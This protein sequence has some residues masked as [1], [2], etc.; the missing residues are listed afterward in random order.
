MRNGTPQREAFISIHPAK[1]GAMSKKQTGKEEEK[2]ECL[3]G[4]SKNL[5]LYMK[6][7]YPVLLIP[8]SEEVRAEQEIA[9]A[10]VATKR[11]RKVVSWTCTSGLSRLTR[12]PGGGLGISVLDDAAKPP[13]KA[14]NKILD[15]NQTGVVYVME[16]LHAHFNNPAVVRLVRDVSRRFR[17]GDRT[18]ILLSPVKKLPPELERDVAVV[19]LALPDRTALRTAWDAIAETNKI[20]QDKDEVEKIMEAARGLTSLEAENAFA[21]AIIQNMTGDERPISELVMAEKADAV[22]KTGVLEYFDAKTI[23]SDIGGLRRL[24]KWLELRKLALTSEAREYGLPSPRGYVMVGLPGCG[25]SLAAKATASVL[26]V[27][28]IRFDVSR[29]FAGLVGQSE[30]NMR[31]AISTI[32]AI[33]NCVVWIDEM[34]KAFAGASGT[35]SGDSGV[36]QRV[37]GQFLTWMQEKKG[38][39]F[40][41]AT[42]NRIGGLP[43]E[44]LRKGRFDEI[45]FVDLPSREEREEILSIH[46][47]SRR[48]EDFLTKMKVEKAWKEC[49]DASEGFSGAEIEESVVSAL[50]TAF[51]RDQTSGERKDLKMDFVYSALLNTTPVSQSQKESLKEMVQWAKVYAVRANDEQATTEKRKLSL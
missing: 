33:G 48:D 51:H 47:R 6:A 27:P 10:A 20:E 4:F 25:K 30:T 35:Q 18:M 42:V 3:S 14:L 41:V 16:D 29:V 9:V 37:F 24:K 36:T 32:E 5:Q 34:E 19:E 13:V 50:Y 31:N 2:G 22:K 17:S 46:V 11:A 38:S 15:E 1:G 28:L 44:L 39:A 7:A 21:K 26:R 45:F 40:V 23:P 8:S 49:I 12:Q 43:P